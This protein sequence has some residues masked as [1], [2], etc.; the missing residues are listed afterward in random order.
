MLRHGEGAAICLSR[1]R[2][3]GSYVQ[4][5]GRP[6]RGLPGAIVELWRFWRRHGT[7][8]DDYDQFELRIVRE[9]RP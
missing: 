9:E 8:R 1:R 3:N 6:V 2:E 4:M 5:E 7:G